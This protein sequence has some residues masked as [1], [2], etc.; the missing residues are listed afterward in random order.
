MWRKQKS[1]LDSRLREIEAEA[2]AVKNSIKALSRAVETKDISARDTA[3]R[4]PSPIPGIGSVQPSLQITSSENRALLE[5]NPSPVS[6]LGRGGLSLSGSGGNGG[7]AGGNS[8]L[9]AD[10]RRN[11]AQLGRYLQTTGFSSERPLR[12]ERSVQRNKAIFMALVVLI[13]LYVVLN[14]IF[15]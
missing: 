9:G 4:A 10:N 13:V 7:S 8:V 15:G 1:K 12:Q 11:D 14:K 2:E 6:P 3:Q 5:T